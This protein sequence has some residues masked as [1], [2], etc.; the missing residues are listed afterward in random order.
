MKRLISILFCFITIAGCATSHQKSGPTPRSGLQSALAGLAHLV[1]SPVQ[2]A[3][4][5]L[6]GISALPYYM[7][8]NIHDI[9]Q[10]LIEAQ[11]S[12]T[13]DDTYDS[14]YGTRLAQVNENGETGEVFRRMKHATKSFQTVLR[15]YGVRDAD[16]YIL[17]SI[18]S[19]N[20]AGFTL[21][22]VVYRPTD[23]IR[24][25]DKYDGKSVRH[26]SNSDR[27]F[28]EPFQ[29]DT[30]GKPLDTII[31][32]A[33]IPRE[34]IKTQKGQSILLTLAA[35]AVVEGE[36]RTDYWQVETRWIAGEYQD[37]VERRM[38]EI[39]KRMKI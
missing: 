27:L 4:G 9:N 16:R 15:H 13:L 21:F 28:Y 6:E 17:T 35:N 32:W 38:T 22:A 34:F 5:L 23:S 33:G 19:A 20:D 25:I 18:D 29:A 37:I 24:V 2:V 11:A 12:I 3:A 14:A 30:T 7:S 10:G 8:T 36:K 31:D 1:L 39:Q 26:F